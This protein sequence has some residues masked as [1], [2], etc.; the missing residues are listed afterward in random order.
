MVSLELSHNRQNELIWLL[1]ERFAFKGLARI[2]FSWITDMYP[3][4][5]ENALH[6]HLL[7][8]CLCKFRLKQ[9]TMLR[10]F[11]PSSK[12]VI[13]HFLFDLQWKIFTEFNQWLFFMFR[14]FSFIQL[15]IPNTSMI[16][17]ITKILW[18]ITLFLPSNSDDQIFFTLLKYFFSHSLFI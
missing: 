11:Y 10:F 2:S 13:F 8:Y 15:S 6:S 17:G 9:L 7:G 3:S 12:I 1:V 16:T 18:D 4:I 5:C 14:N